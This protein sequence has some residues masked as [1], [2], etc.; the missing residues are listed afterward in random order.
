MQSGALS[1]VWSRAMCVVQG[2]HGDIKYKNSNMSCRDEIYN[3]FLK[4]YF[5]MSTTPMISPC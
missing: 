4:D 3:D 5:G 2:R 1:M